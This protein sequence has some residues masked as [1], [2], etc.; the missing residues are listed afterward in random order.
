MRENYC[1]WKSDLGNLLSRRVLGY[2]P[3]QGYDWYFPG[4]DR[5]DTF[6]DK[7]RTDTF[8]S[9]S[10]VERTGEWSNRT[11]SSPIRNISLTDKISYDRNLWWEPETFYQSSHCWQ[12]ILKRNDK[13]VYIE[14]CI[15]Y[16]APRSAMLRTTQG[17][18]DCN[19]FIILFATNFMTDIKVQH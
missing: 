14:S 1:N 19:N 13:I 5:T 17:G 11:E 15:L 8:L 12:P 18:F 10:M 6:Q 9:P 16:P 4:H 7:E 2:F 3:G